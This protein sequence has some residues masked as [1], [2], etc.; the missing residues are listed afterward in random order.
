MLGEMDEPAR[1]D[2]FEDVIQAALRDKYAASP[3]LITGILGELR[4]GGWKPSAFEAAFLKGEVYPQERLLGCLYKIVDV[5]LQLYFLLEVDLPL[6]NSQVFDLGFKKD[7]ANSTPHLFLRHLSIDQTIIVKSRI[8]WERVMNFIYFLET[9]EDL[10]RK[11]SG[12]K[13]KRT[14][15]FKFVESTQRW[16][17]LRP[18]AAE[19]DYFDAKYR[20]PKSTR[21]PHCVRICSSARF[22]TPKRF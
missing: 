20:G 17:F 7:N 13:S 9:G 19:L 15:F 21:H 2:A 3:E 6:Y 14:L 1:I 5:K 18:Y 8:L 11:V 4:S 22:R 12:N 16:S 10:E